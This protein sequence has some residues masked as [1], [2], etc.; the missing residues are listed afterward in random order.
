LIAAAVCG[1]GRA[2]NGWPDGPSQGFFGS[3]QAM[4]SASNIAG[5]LP[6]GRHGRATLVLDLN[7]LLSRP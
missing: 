7:L 2:S 6:N 5:F 3:T 4:T 1:T